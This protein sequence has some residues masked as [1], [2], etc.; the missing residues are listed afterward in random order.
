MSIGQS[1]SLAHTAP[2]ASAAFIGLALPFVQILASALLLHLA[3]PQNGIAP[4]AWVALVPLLFAVRGRSAGKAALIGF[5]FG[6]ASLAAMHSWFFA[7]PG[8][9]AINTSVLFGYLALYPAA[10]CAALALFMRRKLPWVVPGALLWVLIDWLRSHAGPFALPW[11][12]LAH[13]QTS[14]LALLQLAALGG[15]PLISFVVC[16][17]NTSIARA[18]HKRSGIALLCAAGGLGALHLYGALR[19]PAE[20]PSSGTRVAIIQP[21]DDSEPRPARFE[22]L[23]ALTRQAMRER[24]D[25]IVWPESAVDGYAFRPDVRRAV[26]GFARELNAPILFGSADFGKYAKSAGGAADG[27]QFKNQAYLAFPDGAVQGPYVKRRLV[28]FGEYMPLEGRVEWPHWLI[29]RQLHGIAG[30]APGIFR[31]KDG[32]ALGVVICWENYFTALSDALVRAGASVIVQLSDDSDFGASAEPAQHNAATALRAVETGRSWV[33]VSANG[34]S[35]FVDAYGRVGTQVGP[36]GVAGW[37]IAAVP[38]AYAR[39]PY[40][41]FGLSWLWLTAVAVLLQFVAVSIRSSKS[42]EVEQ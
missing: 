19:V 35:F 30:R 34:P 36:I 4:T 11:D 31:L 18:W 26:A 21:A 42:V 7:L 3:V 5:A 16:L 20:G 41:R 8:A 12:P 13:S 14:D 15:A 38:V 2:R 10:W 1:A 25:L 17:A 33:Q 24:P 32:A 29:S 27:T 23:R 22:R 9:N 6:V 28:P 37:A 39:T 40:E